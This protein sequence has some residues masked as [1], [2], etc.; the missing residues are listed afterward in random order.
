MP[1]SCAAPPPASPSDPFFELSLDPL[2]TTGLAICRSIVERH[3]G[4]FGLESVPGEGST[5]TFTLPVA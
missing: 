3:G 4:T 2:V 5:F 1:E